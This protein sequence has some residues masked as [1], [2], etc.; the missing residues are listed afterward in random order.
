MKS[1]FEGSKSFSPKWRKIDEVSFSE[2]PMFDSIETME[3]IA[4]NYGSQ[5]EITFNDG[6]V[7]YVGISSE[8]D[9]KVGEIVDKEKCFLVTLKRGGEYC[10]KLKW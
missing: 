6:T 9:P 5:M 1:I 3:V 8:A 7:H 4:G 10:Y 2:D